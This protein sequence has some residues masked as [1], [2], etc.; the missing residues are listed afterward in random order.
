[1]TQP[2]GESSGKGGAPK[3]QSAAP[4]GA[5]KPKDAKPAAEKKPAAPKTIAGHPMNAT[6][7]MGVNKDSKPYGPDNNPKR[8]GSAAAVRF[9]LYKDGMTLEEALKA[10]LRS[11][12]IG[13][14]V[15]PTRKYIVITD[16]PK[17]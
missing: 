12:D 1:M 3:P 9:A 11:D 14:D 13:F 15:A 8:Q 10:G 7:K 5:A 2:A 17:A 6:I 16:P 4:A